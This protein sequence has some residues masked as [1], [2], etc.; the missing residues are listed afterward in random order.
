MD[1]TFKQEYDLKTFLKTNRQAFEDK[2]LSEADNVKD[3]VDEIKYI[4]NINLIENAHKLIIFVVDQKK[5]EVIDFAKQEGIAWA[6]NSLT[7]SFKL[8]WV[9][10]I[11][12]TLWYFLAEYDRRQM[13]EPNR[14]KFYEIEK[15]VN[16]LVDEFFKGFFINYSKFKDELIESQRVQ[17]E[18]LSVP[19]IPISSSVSIL[20]LIGTI[21]SQRASVI[22]EK[23]L[24]EIGKIRVQ[25]LVMDLSGVAE[26]EAEATS[27]FL[28]LLDGIS[29]MGCRAII[30][31]LH[32]EIVANILELDIEFRQKF[33]T[34][35]TLQKAM[36]KYFKVEN[37]INEINPADL[38]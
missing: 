20:P 28:K 1:I 31:G 19:I 25:T 7:L 37:K 4:G 30:T 3:K 17:V 15:K 36:E 38:V 11:R 33:E 9:Q 8:E 21:D 27:N 5:Q 32:P 22:E 2:L 24:V 16:N 34:K 14:D 35:G 26:M 13:E 29:M 10:S 6:K 12:R 18:N 23:V